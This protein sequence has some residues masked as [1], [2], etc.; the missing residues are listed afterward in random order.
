MRLYRTKVAEIA[1]DAIMALT[2]TGDIEVNDLEEAQ[3]DLVAIMEEFLRRDGELRRRVKD[4]MARHNMPYGDYGRVRKGVAEEMAHPLGD[5]VERFLA[6]Q[7]IENLMITRFVDEVYAD[8]EDMYK[9]VLEVIRSFHVD[10]EALREEAASKVK[11]VKF[12]T[13]EYE[14]ALRDA[15]LEVK[16]RHGLIEDRRARGGAHG[17]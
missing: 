13:V 4:H 16:R 17:R 10:E 6:R 3:Q 8:D 2:T 9:K 7:F 14:I 15:L 11:N 1:R 5:D 12:G